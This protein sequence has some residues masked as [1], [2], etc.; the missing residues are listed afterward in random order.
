MERGGGEG[1]KIFIF[2]MKFLEDLNGEERGERFFVMVFTEL[3]A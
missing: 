2:W 1:M 3:G